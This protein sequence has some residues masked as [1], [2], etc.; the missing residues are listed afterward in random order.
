MSIDFIK[1]IGLVCSY[2]CASQPSYLINIFEVK[3]E[4]LFTKLC[5]VMWVRRETEID[6]QCLD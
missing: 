2:H 3:D 6:V 5:C 1:I 4:C